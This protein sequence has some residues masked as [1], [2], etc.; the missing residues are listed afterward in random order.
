MDYRLRET[1]EIVSQGEIR[2]RN[3]NTSLPAV[4]Y[5]NICDFL[6]IDPILQS[7]QPQVGELEVVLLDGAV[8]DSLGNWV[9]NYIVKPMFSDLE[10]TNED[11]SVSI[12][13]KAEQEAEDL[14]AKFK[15]TVP[16]SISPR[17]ARLQLLSLGL[18]D[19]LEAV[20]TTNRAWQIEWEYATEVKR[21]SPLIDAVATQ[22]GLTE[23]QIDQMFKEASVL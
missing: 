7:P 8:Q 11:G 13:T 15:A 16:V 2:R 18:L 5:K 22:A 9:Q 4:F 3:S 21:N 17:Q 12:K 14:K 23:E 6:G 20:I 1:G 19:D 10:F